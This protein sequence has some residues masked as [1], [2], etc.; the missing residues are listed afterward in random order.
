M[1]NPELAKFEVERLLTPSIVKLSKN[2][3]FVD[4]SI[5]YYER[6]AYTKKINE[7]LFFCKEDELEGK[8]KEFDWSFLKGSYRI[9]S[10]LDVADLIYRQISEPKVDLRNPDNILEVFKHENYVYFSKVV[11]KNRQ[12][13]LSRRSH[14]YPRPHP[15]GL[16]PTL[17][18]ACINILGIDK[19]EIVDPFCGSGGVLIEAGL[20]GFDVKGYDINPRLVDDA[21]INLRHFGIENFDIAKDDSLNG[22]GADYIVTDIP[23]G[24]STKISMGVQELAEQFIESSEFKKMVMVCP[25][26][27]QL[28]EYVKEFVLYVHKSLSKKVYLIE[29]SH[30]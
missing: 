17:A 12:D 1:Q 23:Y 24:R 18:R 26:E 5:D 9:N 10:G 4:G 3:L 25:S 16:Y 6:L 8:I 28:K 20:M 21:K 15:T 19:G 11:W 7:I 13:F 22:V 2:I 27:V 30:G 14:L 29:F